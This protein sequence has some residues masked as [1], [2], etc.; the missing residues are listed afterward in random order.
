MVIKKMVLFMLALGALATNSFA[1]GP[2]DAFKT[3]FLDQSTQFAVP[4]ILFLVLIAAAITY[5]RT[6]DWTISLVVGGIS[7]AIIG[8]AASLVTSFS[9]FAF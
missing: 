2:I 4:V 9:G 6:K 1:A 8:G 5:M 7:A 3:T